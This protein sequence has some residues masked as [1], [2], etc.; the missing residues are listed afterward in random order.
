MMRLF[1]T[2]LLL[3]TSYLGFSMTLSEAN[4]LYKQD[5]FEE[6]VDAYSSIIANGDISADLF[7][8]LGNAYYR[9]DEKGKSIWA[10]E[11]ALNLDPDHEDALFNLSFVNAQTVD[12][13][14][15]S[16]KGLGHWF[17]GIVYSES[18]NF[19][20]YL[21]V[22]CSFLLTLF[23]LLFIHSANGSRRNFYLLVT[24]ILI[25]G[26]MSSVTLASLHRARLEEKNFAVVISETAEIKM[27]PLE[28]ANSSFSLG[29]G[30]KIEI[31]AKEN[32]WIQIEINGNKGWVSNESIWEL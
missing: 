8:N 13:I 5:H 10:Y 29:A 22:A 7:Y 17:E 32:G 15:K 23:I 9:I 16:K 25:I 21:S 14:D 27:S 19:W 2:Y 6:A 30:A 1:V 31:I 24:A 12:K 11:S 20:A 28:N 4:E 3:T 26:L 18:I